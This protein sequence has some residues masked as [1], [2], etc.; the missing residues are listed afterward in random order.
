MPMETEITITEIAMGDN[1]VVR[2][3][4]PESSWGQGGR[5]TAI[6]PTGITMTCGGANHLV[7]LTTAQ[8]TAGQITRETAFP[9]SECAEFSEECRGAVDYRYQGP[10]RCEGHW[11]ARC[12]RMDRINRDFPDSPF[13]PSW[14]DPTYAGE[15]WDGDY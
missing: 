2:P 13:A 7:S 14:F 9:A 3:E 1:L 10:L 6:L 5:V 4:F 15:S 12:D 8:L 11:N